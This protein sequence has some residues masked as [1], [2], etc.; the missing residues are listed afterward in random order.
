MGMALRTMLIT[1]LF[2]FNLKLYIVYTSQYELTYEHNVLLYFRSH[3]GIKSYSCD[4]CNAGIVNKPHL[5]S[6]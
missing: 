3:Y 5:L 1:T 6:F 2:Q 4:M